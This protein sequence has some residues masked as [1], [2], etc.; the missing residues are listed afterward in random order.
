VTQARQPMLSIDLL[1]NT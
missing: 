1:R